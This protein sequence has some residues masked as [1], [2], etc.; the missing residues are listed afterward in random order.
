MA[1]S[2]FSDD[3]KYYSI[4][5]K[6]G[7]L[8]IWDTE[9][10][11]LKQEY[12][13]DL[14]LTSPPSCLQWITVSNLA[15]SS[16]S[17]GKRKQSFSGQESQC[18]VLGTTSGKILVYS[19]TQAKVE[20]VISEDKQ[21]LNQNITALDWHRRYG[22]YSSNKA[23]FVIEWDLHSGSVRNKYNVI[24]DNS[25][26]GN[27]VSA[28]KIVP[29]TQKSPARFLVTA[30]WQVCLWRLLDDSAIIIKRLGHNIT[31]GVLLAVVNNN[32]ATWLLEGSLNERLLSFWDITVTGEHL[33]QVNGDD[34]TPSKRQRK[35]S[36]TSTTS[37]PTYSFVLEDAPRFIDVQ[38]QQENG[39]NVLKLAAATRSGVVHYY[40]HMLNGAS[41]KPI[42]PSVTVQV[43]TPG[44]TPLPL[45]CCRLQNEFLTL[46][47]SLGTGLI[48]ENLTPDLSSKTQVLIRGDSKA[49]KKKSKK[50]NDT[51]KVRADGN[52]D[53]T[54]V[55]PMGGNVSRKRQTPGAQVEVP[56]EA[57][58]EN[59]S[60]DPKSRSK[61]A[62]NQNLT[63]LLM[64]G[65]H[66]NDKGL[67]LMVL[68]QNDSNVAMRTLSCLP[69]AYVQPL[70]E[71][72]LDMAARKTSQCASVCTWVGAVLRCHSAMILA[73][74]H[75]DHQQYLTRILALFTHRR[76]HLCQLLN[77]KGRLD[78]TISQRTAEDNVHDDQD[79][80]LEYNDTSSDEEMELEQYQSE[81]EQSWSDKDGEG[82]EQPVSESDSGG[83]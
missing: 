60:L 10:N 3:G 83:E 59:L 77:L 82:E 71:H 14:H 41:T 49:A 7:R 25:K 30:S 44:A 74:T 31:K 42:K 38:L 76:S 12:T 73:A 27:Y 28:I 43:T 37:T 11:V 15:G 48:F 52:T 1:L 62:V 50:P 47:Y 34:S 8:R 79:A 36:I 64:Q 78:L 56:M 29:H 68:Q 2:A 16:Q 69:A 45:Q 65:L 5:S 19:V 51:N 54:Y 9:T 24:I 18:I 46:G 32:N 23:G 55:E 57:R 6:E 17:S 80:L 13:P 40:G 35:K 72:L 21:N 58:L 33:P 4:I 63:K 75:T 67:I 81:S 20:N 61:S 53:V 26:Q 39:G 70:L 22:L 66:S